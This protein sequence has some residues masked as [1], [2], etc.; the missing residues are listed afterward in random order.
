MD[1]GSQI[2]SPFPRS[3]LSSTSQIIYTKLVK[4]LNNE[5]VK[6]DKIDSKMVKKNK[7]AETQDFLNSYIMI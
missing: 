7:H 4:K 3:Y 5:I 2:F 1:S 6:K